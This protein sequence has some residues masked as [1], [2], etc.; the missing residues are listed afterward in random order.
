MRLGDMMNL[1]RTVSLGGMMSL[2]DMVSFDGMM[3]RNGLTSLGGMMG[4]DNKRNP[5]DERDRGVGEYPTGN[6]TARTNHLARIVN[7]GD[8]KSYTDTTSVTTQRNPATNPADMTSPGGTGNHANQRSH[9]GTRNPAEE[10]SSGS[11]RRNK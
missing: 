11:K 2:S 6:P 1:D 5:L 10:K 4:L 8:A 9:D 3:S 7:H